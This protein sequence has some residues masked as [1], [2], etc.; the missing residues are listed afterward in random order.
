MPVECDYKPLVSIL[1]T[2]YN[3][4]NFIAEAIESVLA[5]TYGNFELL[6][7]DD[8]STDYTY[9]TAQKYTLADSRIKVYVNEKNLGDYPNRNKAASLASGEFI[10]YV[11]SDDKLLPDTITNIFKDSNG[12]HGLNFAMY[13]RHSDMRF[14][15]AGSDALK[16][17][18]FDKQFLYM[19]P[20]GTFI[21][22]SF[23]DSVGGYPEK[24]G[25]AN[26]MYFN[27]KA[28]C[29]SEIYL[30]PYEFIYYRIHDG[31]EINNH[32][33][34]LYNNYNYMR[35]ALIELPLP[36]TKNQLNWLKKKNKRRF[37][38]NLF[39][40]FIKTKNIKKTREAYK[41]ASFS[42]LNIVQGVLNFN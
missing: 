33:N 13:W 5:S 7:I 22:K 21:R 26:D 11:D 37:V 23:F 8:C 3:R 31:Q 25:P 24:Y 39:N 14:Q 4:D 15:L 29:F 12:G 32:F 41:N 27:L 18:F 10:M 1:M 19:G 17:H 35:D 30:F 2:A 9:A 38:V 16:M 36:F 6:V 40:Y 42:L 34:Y 20:G 28:C